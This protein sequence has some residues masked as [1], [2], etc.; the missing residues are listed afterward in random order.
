MIDRPRY[1]WAATDSPLVAL[2]RRRMGRAKARFPYALGK[3]D[4]GQVPGRLASITILR[5]RDVFRAAF[6][7]FDPAIV[8]RFGENEIA[9]LLADLERNRLGS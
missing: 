6:R 3:V 4:A 7:G 8:A 2:P 5:K 1:R 9:A